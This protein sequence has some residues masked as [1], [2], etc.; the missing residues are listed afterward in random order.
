MALKKVT[1]EKISVKVRLEACDGLQDFEL[2]VT[3]EQLAILQTLERES[4]PENE[5]MSCNP[6]LKVTL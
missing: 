4:A 2:E 1:P 5:Y 6:A 3:R